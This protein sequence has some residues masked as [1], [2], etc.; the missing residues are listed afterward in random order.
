M[1]EVVPPDTRTLEGIISA[2][3]QQ[4][5]RGVQVPCQYDKSSD[6]NIFYSK[7]VQEK[8]TDMQLLQRFYFIY[9][10][11]CGNC[12]LSC[13]IVFHIQFPTSYFMNI[14]PILM[15]FFYLEVAFSKFEEKKIWTK[16]KK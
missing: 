3:Y 12:P 11:T 2:D 1:R 13:Y 14:A 15:C 16:D 9:F 5:G 6:N 8:K 10:F 4:G 7:K